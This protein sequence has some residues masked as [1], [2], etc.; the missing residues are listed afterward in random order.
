MAGHRERRV[1]PGVVLWANDGAPG[2]ILPDGCLDLIWNGAGLVVAGP[3][4]AARRHPGGLPH[5]GL[6]FS[7][8]RGPAHLAVRADELRDTSVALDAV[9]S[10]A[11]ARELTE[12]VADDPAR[13]LAGVAT[14]T[15]PD[16]AD[17]FGARV[18]AAL[19]RGADVAGLAD[20]LGTTTRT[21]HR[22]CL[23]VFGYGPQHLGRV[24]RLQRALARARA[25]TPWAEVAASEGFADQPHLAREVRALAGTTPTALLG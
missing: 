13:V 23:P 3:D 19:A 21:L 17:R 16:P 11:A 10:G 24:L 6:R 18:F 9:W 4:A 20:A 22:R 15:P 5:V 14:A 7:H 12:R 8:G 1:A 2:T 25:G